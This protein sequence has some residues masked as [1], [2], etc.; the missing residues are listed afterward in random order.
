MVRN[1]KGGAVP[2]VELPITPMLDM[3]FQLLTF[4]IFTY[5][6]SAVEGQMEFSLPA[7]G[8]PPAPVQ[9]NDPPP[10]PEDVPA[11]EKTQYTVVLRAQRDGVNHGVLSSVPVETTNGGVQPV[12][13]LEALAR[14]FKDRRATA[15]PADAVQIQADSKLKYAFVTA[16]MDSCLKAGWNRVGFAPPPDLG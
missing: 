14:Y 16:A 6:P 4:F 3:T 12:A 2:E 11:T 10:T 7:T 15:G 13:N 1:R 8:T 5:H 9:V